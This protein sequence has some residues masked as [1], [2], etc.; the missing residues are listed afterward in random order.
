MSLPLVVLACTSQTGS[1]AA[2]PA[3]S[4]TAVAAT[5]QVQASA[6]TPPVATPAAGTVV[7]A[8]TPIA[9]ATTTAEP[10][11]TPGSPA[12]VAQTEGPYYKANPPQRASLLE[13]G[14]GGTRLVVTGFVFTTDCKPVEGARVDFWQADDQGRYDNSGYRLRGYQLT[15]GTGRYQLE[16]VVP[17][18]YPGRTRHIHVKVQAPNGPMLTTQLYFP[19]EPGN[20]G[21]RIF[22]ERLVM[23]VQEGANGEL[24]TFDFIVSGR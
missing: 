10:A 23:A 14:V 11:C 5:A 2:P 12:T 3:T 15:D 16:T 24:G 17:G 6:A 18:L 21:D 4:T 1:P 9:E 19:D 7:A 13:P 20:A 22:D 8:A